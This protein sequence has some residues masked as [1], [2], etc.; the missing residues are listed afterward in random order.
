MAF[1]SE[2][3]VQAVL[4]AFGML[5]LLGRSSTE[6][7]LGVIAEGAGVSKSTAHRLI[8]TLVNAGYVATGSAEGTYRIGVR[9]LRFASFVRST[10]ELISVARP[11]LERLVTVAEETAM[12]GVRDGTQLLYLDIEEPAQTIRLARVP[13]GVG[14]LHCT[15][16][17]KALLSFGDEGIVTELLTAGL[18]GHT[19][20]SLVEADGLRAELDRVRA[21][22]FAINDQEH[23]DGVRAV[24]MP[25][26]GTDGRCEAAVSLAGPAYRMTDERIAQVLPPLREAAEE[27]SARLGHE[28]PDAGMFGR[29][30]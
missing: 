23:L 21:Q 16:L 28:G 26:F 13:G 10:S 9:L 7:S 27:L 6:V 29:A 5:E 17:G 20:N 11:I 30:D 15:A 24:G 8:S 4:N 3:P 18:T 1:G 22:G 25:V 19:S 14:P 2:P 12:I